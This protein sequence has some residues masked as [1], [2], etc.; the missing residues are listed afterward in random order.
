MVISNSTRLDSTES[1]QNEYIE[2][3]KNNKQSNENDKYRSDKLLFI[4]FV[5]LPREDWLGSDKR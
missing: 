3:K 5:S 2:Q 1:D 4:L